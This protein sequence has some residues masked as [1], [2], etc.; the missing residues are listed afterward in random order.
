MEN[1]GA[2][3]TSTPRR[4]AAVPSRA[5]TSGRPV[6]SRLCL[7]ILRTAAYVPSV[8]AARLKR[9]RSGGAPAIGVATPSA[10]D[11]TPLTTP[12]PETH[13]TSS[14]LFVVALNAAVNTATDDDP[15][16]A[17]VYGLIAGPAS[18]TT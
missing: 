12:R 18:Y 14:R 8:P 7:T 13:G 3:C 9:P 11:V 5:T 2:T 6:C 15:T 4:A 10:S 1:V 17:A 16:V